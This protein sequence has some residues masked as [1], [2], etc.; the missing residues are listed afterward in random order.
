MLLWLWCFVLQ[1]RRKPVSNIAIFGVFIQMES[2]TIISGT[3]SQEVHPE[4][5]LKAH[6]DVAFMLGQFKIC[7]ILLYAAT[8]RIQ[9]VIIPD[10]MTKWYFG[11]RT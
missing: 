5:L 6:I 10:A 4:K 2:S 3:Y 7:I 1:E 8:K 9:T 11:N